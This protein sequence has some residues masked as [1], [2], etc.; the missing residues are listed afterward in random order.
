MKICNRLEKSYKEYT[1]PTRLIF[2]LYVPG[3]VAVNG[4]ISYASQEPWLF[5]SS[6]KQNILF[7]DI[8]DF[9][10]YNDAIESCA[11]TYDLS[12]LKHGDETLVADR[13]HNLS[14]GQQARINLARA[15]YGK[16]DI[17]L[18]DDSLTSLDESVQDFIFN[19]SI[20]ELLASKIVVM[21]SQ[22]PKHIERADIVITLGKGKISSILRQNRI[23]KR[24]PLKTENIVPQN[25]KTNGNVNFSN[26]CNTF[27]KLEHEQDRKVYDEAKK[28][29][30]VDL[31]V[32]KKYL[33]S[34][35]S[36]IL[37]AV[38]IFLYTLSQYFDSYSDKLLTSW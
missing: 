17:Y 2:C 7:G 11:L 36:L 6:I 16:N 31:E 30:R 21:V 25:M 33:H 27:T 1:L 26:N 12:L 8:Y 10:R 28:Q 38:I 9:S 14:K 3:K 34:G 20:L 22:N 4:T 19:K 15:I 37:V 35:G 32:Y 13:G 24:L 18:L 23:A 29:G 5:P